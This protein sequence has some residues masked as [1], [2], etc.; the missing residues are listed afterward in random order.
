MQ[1]RRISACPQ[2]IAN[3]AG[4]LA[5]FMLSGFLE[6][7]LLV[8]LSF[9]LSTFQQNIFTVNPLILSFAFDTLFIRA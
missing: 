9:W 5:D 1:V 3:F 4:E 8:S 7:R 2:T 6:V